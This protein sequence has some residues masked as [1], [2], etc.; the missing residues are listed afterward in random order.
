MKF[1]IYDTNIVNV[2]YFCLIT[3]TYVQCM[4]AINF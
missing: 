4:E 1:M 3:S 2:L